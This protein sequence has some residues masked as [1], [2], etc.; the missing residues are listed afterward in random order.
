MKRLHVHVGVT[1]L[2][3]SIGFYSTLF[4]AEPT[5]TKDDY[6]KWMLEDPRVNFAISSGNHAAKGIEHLGIQV[7]NGEELTEVYD[8]LK[9]ADRPVLEEGATTCCYAKSEKSWIADP[10]GIVWEAFLTNGDATIYGDSPALA[11]L[12]TNAADGA[13]CAPTVPA[14]TASCCG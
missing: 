11:A 1:D 14:Q 2:S 6:A 5:V 10:D 3:T 9:A 4:G 8:R 7:E 12:S 13:C